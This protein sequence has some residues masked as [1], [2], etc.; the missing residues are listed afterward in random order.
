MTFHPLGEML[1]NVSA[2]QPKQGKDL[3]INATGY[4]PLS[5]GC[6]SG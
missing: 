1:N 3:F 6:S 2:A 5:P 4:V